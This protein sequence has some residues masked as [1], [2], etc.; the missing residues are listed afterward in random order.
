M[1]GDMAHLGGSRC[2]RGGNYNVQ[3]FGFRI[4]SLV[5]RSL[6]AYVLLRKPSKG[7]VLFEKLLF[8]VVMTD[9]FSGGYLDAAATVRVIPLQ[10]GYGYFPRTGEPVFTVKVGTP[11]KRRDFW[12]FL[13]A[14]VL[15]VPIIRTTL[16]GG[17]CWGPHFPGEYSE[18]GDGLKPRATR[19]RGCW[20]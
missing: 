7:T 20:F 5:L 12:T 15:G 8:V 14:S 2:V 4:C 3:G 10:T 1:A 11:K 19:V 16:F 18:G 9:L 6:R 17:L 13:G